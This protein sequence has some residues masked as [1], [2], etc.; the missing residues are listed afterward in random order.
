MHF[1][2]SAELVRLFT[3]NNVIPYRVQFFTDAA[4]SMRQDNA[5]FALHKQMNAFWHHH[6]GGGALN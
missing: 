3:I 1:Q 2:H 5:F 4:H 6:L